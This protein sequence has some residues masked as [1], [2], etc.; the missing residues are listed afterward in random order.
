MLASSCAPAQSSKAL[1]SLV[2]S[3][4]SPVYRLRSSVLGLQSSVLGG[5]NQ[6]GLVVERHSWQIGLNLNESL[7]V[8]LVRALGLV[9][10]IFTRLVFG[11]RFS[12]Y[13]YYFFCLFV[14]VFFCLLFVIIVVVSAIN[15]MRPKTNGTYATH[16][17]VWVI[18]NRES[19][20]ETIAISIYFD[21]LSST[22]F[23]SLWSG[24]AEHSHS[25]DHIRSDPIYT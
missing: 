24:P 17:F 10:M 11:F 19:D 4:Q 12:S 18:I 21:R 23:T 14:L 22:I 7:G 9:R 13:F 15:Q 6:I 5:S 20:G 25:T 16:N 8:F 3:L 1:Q 2:S